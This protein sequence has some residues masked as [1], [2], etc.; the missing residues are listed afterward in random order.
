VLLVERELEHTT[1][2]CRLTSVL[3]MCVLNVCSLCVRDNV[4]GG[5][6]TDACRCCAGK[7]SSISRA[8]SCV[9]CGAGERCMLLAGHMMPAYPI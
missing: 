3:Q 2:L 4:G 8:T 1:E 5:C 9:D 7:Y 6:L